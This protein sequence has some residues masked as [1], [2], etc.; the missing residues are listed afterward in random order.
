M[1]KLLIILF[2]LIAIGLNATTYYVKTGGSD[3]AAGTS[4]ALAWATLAKVQSTAFSAGDSILLERGST[5]RGSLYKDAESGSAGNYIYFG[6]YGTGAKPL[7]L[8]SKSLSV[9]GDWTNDAGNVWKTT[10][11]LG[12]AQ[13]D[14]SNMVFNSETA[15]GFKQISKVACDAQGDFFYSDGDDL[16]YMYSVGNPGTFYTHI[17]ACGNYDINQG[18][19]KWYDSDYIIVENIDVRYSS[20]AGI[21]LRDCNNCIIQNCDVSWIGGEYVNPAVDATR[22]G[23]G[24]SIILNCTNIIARY[25]KINQCF[26]AGISPQGWG[27]FTQ[28]NLQFYY[29]T[30][31]NCWYS[32]ELWTDAGV[33]MTNTH[34][35]NNTCY[36][37]GGS[38]SASQRPDNLYSAHICIWSFNGDMTNTIIKNNIFDISLQHAVR[39][40]E[41]TYPGL[42][43]DN[44][45]YNVADVAYTASG[46]FETLAEWQADCGQ[47]VNSVSGDPLFLTPI[48][49]HLQATSPAIDTGTDVGLTE[50]Y[51]GNVVPFNSIPDIGA[52]EYGSHEVTSGAPLGIGSGNNLLVD[53]NGRQIVIR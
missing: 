53:K 49:F 8:G 50:D 45:L 12:T 47:E 14:I 15:Y 23:N 40:H 32:Y 41:S 7:I 29:N 39:I 17:E 31:S 1:K 24:I 51:D 20:G 30:I 28:N 18:L 10:A 13:N 52:Y 22:L 44:N 48:N 43:I 25:N 9:T 27:V 11:T 36:N 46:S 4:D 16:V 2:L 42:I 26:D 5:F 6:A 33:V 34:F 3:V 38:F 37:S 21:E 35:Y 19:I